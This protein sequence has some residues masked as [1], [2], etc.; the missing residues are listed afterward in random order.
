MS[1]AIDKTRPFLTCH[2]Y[3][4]VLYIPERARPP[5]LSLSFLYLLSKAAQA[6]VN[7]S[8]NLFSLNALRELFMRLSADGTEMLYLF[9]LSF[10]CISFALRYY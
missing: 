7:V 10:Q 8:I 1:E 6:R 4:I 5:S 3:T 9:S 2:K